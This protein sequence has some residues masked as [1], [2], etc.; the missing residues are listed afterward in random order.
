MST[1]YMR[2]RTTC[3]SA[4]PARPS[5]A[6]MFL[7]VCTVWAYGSPAPTMRPSAS[8]AVVPETHGDHTAGTEDDLAPGVPHAHR[9][10]RHDQADVLDPEGGRARDRPDVLGPLPAGLVARP[11]DGETAD[12]DQ[13]E[14]PLVEHPRLVRLLETLDGDPRHRPLTPPPAARSSRRRTASSRPGK[15]SARRTASPPRASCSSA[16]APWRSRAPAPT[17]RPP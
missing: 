8:V 13:L 7:R 4:A 17:P 5:A 2:V 1:T 9:P 16:R 6:S 10:P 15:P 11:P 12:P 3:S 14:P